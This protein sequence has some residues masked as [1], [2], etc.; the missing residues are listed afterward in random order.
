MQ[1]IPYIPESSPFTR[2]QRLWL[3]G[4]LAGMFSQATGEPIAAPVPGKPLLVLYGSQTGTAEGLA[5]KLH[6]EAQQRGLVSRMLAM[7]ALQ[8]ADL[9]AA[10]NVALITSTYGDGEP[11][12]NAQAFWS[13][14]QSD[15]APALP[16][17][18]YSVLALGDMNYPAFCEFGKQCDARLAQLG[19]VPLHPRVDCDVDYDAPALSWRESLLQ[20]LS[21][22]SSPAL[23]DDKVEAHAGHDKR[24]PFPARL[25]TNRLLNAAGSAKEVRHFEISL[26]GSGLTYEAGDALG[27]FPSNCPT[28]VSEL[29]A[30]LGCDGEEAVPSTDGGETSLRHALANQYDIM[31]PPPDFLAAAASRPGGEEL[32]ALLEPSRA[33]ELKEWLVGREIADVLLALTERFGAADFVALLRKLQPRLYSISSSPNAHPGKVHVTVGIVRY[34]THGR[35]R[36]GVCST[37]LADRCS[38]TGRLPVFVQTSHGFRLPGDLTRPVIMVGPGTGIA[39]FRAFLEE[40]RISGSTGGNW[41]FFGDQRSATDFLYREEL[42]AMRA[43]GHLSRLD[44]AF[45]RDQAEKIYVQHRMLE[46]AGE[47]WSWLEQ[48]AY[49]YVC[50]DASRMARDVDAAL[51]SVCEQAGGLAPEAAAAY[52][53]RLK[54]EKRYQRDVY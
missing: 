20:S 17:L 36:K 30:L 15:T 1:A 49:F 54:E 5:R 7:D 28:Q 6:K 25:L 11:P 42:E 21:E 32:R 8:P 19:A 46:A 10:E 26:E 23:L 22:S 3:N 47:L 50:G 34:A 18:R 24:N 40:R 33:G 37:F 51:H 27:I 48:G 45:S 35:N 4:Y 53:A 39:P 9:A 41:L 14:L 12:D 38:E 13:V 44:V 2:E 43:D 52:V 31:K 16:H 29:L